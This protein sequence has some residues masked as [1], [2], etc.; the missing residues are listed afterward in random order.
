M[1]NIVSVT[2]QLDLPATST[3][4]AMWREGNAAV[5]GR[6]TRGDAGAWRCAGTDKTGATVSGQPI[7]L[8]IYGTRF[9]LVYTEW[10]LVFMVLHYKYI[11]FHATSTRI[12]R[13][14]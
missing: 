12:F 11:Y 13:V 3:G 9:K 7:H 14:S 10:F 2:Q 5:V 8:L 6:A 1:N 4:E